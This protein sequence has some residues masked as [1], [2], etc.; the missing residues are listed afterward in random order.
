[1]KNKS[2][3]PIKPMR[4]LKK[5]H[6]LALTNSQ[7]SKARK[8]AAANDVSLSAIASAAVNLLC[9]I[10]LNKKE[11][12]VK[13]SLRKALGAPPEGI[14]VRAD[15]RLDFLEQAMARIGAELQSARA[16]IRSQPHP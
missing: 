6:G 13:S 16:E 7:I 8:W 3:A 14:E 5:T 1:M 15:K 4:E 12:R 10:P 11:L 2:N 9:E